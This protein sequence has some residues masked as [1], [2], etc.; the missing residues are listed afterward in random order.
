MRTDL[1]HWIALSFV[2]GLGGVHIGALLEKFGS[3]K[4]IFAASAG[5]L[6]SVAG[7]GKK[8][9]A[10]ISGFKRWQDVE[11][12]EA[13]T[14]KKGVALVSIHDPGYP[15]LL[16]EIH[17]PPAVLYVRGT[18]TDDPCRIAVVGSRQPTEYGKIVA[19]RM[20]EDLGRRGVCVVSGM[21]R[22]IDSIAHRAC[23]AVRRRTIA[24]LGSGIDNV[25]PPEHK[26]L[27][28]EISEHGAVI[29]EFPLGT[30]PLA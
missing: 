23:L 28:D 6:M 1:S 25:Y 11:R 18:L 29:S 5:D 21:A 9:A 3:A 10:A 4:E 12:E 30:P 27:Y 2:Q 20:A 15:G 17:D 26:K 7:I 8:T 16:R 13:A 24:V 19:G 14:H 22:G